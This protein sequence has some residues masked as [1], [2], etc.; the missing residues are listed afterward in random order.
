MTRVFF[1][2]GQ[3]LLEDHDRLP[4]VHLCGFEH[5]GDGLARVEVSGQVYVSP[6]DEWKPEK[7]TGRVVVV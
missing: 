5:Y 3:E 1:Q 2:P 6:G 4:L 7:P